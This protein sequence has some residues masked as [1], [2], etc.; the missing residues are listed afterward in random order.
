MRKRETQKWINSSKYR[1]NSAYL[2][3]IFNIF[4]NCSY[5]FAMD[6]ISYE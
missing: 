1:F 6:L 5:T 4:G 3:K 2:W